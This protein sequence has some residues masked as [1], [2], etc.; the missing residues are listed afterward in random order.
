LGKESGLQP[1]MHDVTQ[2]MSRMVAAF[3]TGNVSDLGRFIDAEY[4]DHQGIGG[5]QVRGPDGF[6]NV[7][8]L[9]RSGFDD[10]RVSVQD[11]IG[12]PDRA[13]AR[14]LWV[15]R[16]KSDGMSVRRET[17]DIVRFDNG[18]AIEHWGHRTWIDPVR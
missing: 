18:R 12:G 4:L 10:L 6:R 7:V 11:M 9:A 3:D 13:A 15:G 1:K 5:K 8:E 16:R 2:L 17:I 14:L